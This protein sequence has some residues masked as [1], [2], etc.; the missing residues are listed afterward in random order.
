MMPVDGWIDQKSFCVNNLTIDF[1]GSTIKNIGS[2]A[3]IQPLEAFMEGRKILNEIKMRNNEFNFFPF[4]KHFA[5]G[6]PKTS[7]PRDVF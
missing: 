3:V 4:V 2:E 1:E 7:I 5:I 6:F